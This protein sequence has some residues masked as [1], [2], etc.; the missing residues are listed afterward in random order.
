MILQWNRVIGTREY[1]LH[2]IW[3][4]IRYESA[5]LGYFRGTNIVIDH[6]SI[7]EDPALMRD[8]CAYAALISFIDLGS[9]NF[10]SYA[11]GYVITIGY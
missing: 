11:D 3:F 5:M 10:P 1:G 8:I 2:A 6:D 4:P 9:I 7:S